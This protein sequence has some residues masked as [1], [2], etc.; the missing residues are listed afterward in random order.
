[1]KVY[2]SLCLQYLCHTFVP[3]FC[4]YSNCACSNFAPGV[5]LWIRKKT[6]FVCALFCALSFSLPGSFHVGSTKV[7]C[8]S[9][10]RKSCYRKV[11]AWISLDAKKTCFSKHHFL[12]AWHLS[13]RSSFL[14]QVQKPLL[15]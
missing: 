11:V 8:E 12:L 1:M 13:C 15:E 5:L 9:L 4:A 10:V 6:C 2:F 14:S 3:H 7:L